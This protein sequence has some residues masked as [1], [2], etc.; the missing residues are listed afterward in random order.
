[1]FRA[2]CFTRPFLWL[3]FTE[4][5]RR[6]IPGRTHTGFCIPLARILVPGR[7]HRGSAPVVQAS[8]YTVG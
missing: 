7:N 3:L 4:V 6:R 1:M 2:G 8:C 5:Y